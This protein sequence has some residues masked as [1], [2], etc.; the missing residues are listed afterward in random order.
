M[1]ITIIF[2]SSKSF[3]Y[4]NLI[5]ILFIDF[6]NVHLRLFSFNLLISIISCSLFVFL[7]YDLTIKIKI[8]ILLKKYYIDLFYYI[9]LLLLKLN[10]EFIM[11]NI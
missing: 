10:F 9:D 2:I 1:I 7:L 8:N 5:F 4:S 3:I 11:F 6:Y